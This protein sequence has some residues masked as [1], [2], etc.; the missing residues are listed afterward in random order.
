MSKNMS[1]K[2]FI[3][4]KRVCFVGGCPN[5]KG[6]GYGD[7]IDGYDVVVK[8]NGSLFLGGDDYFIDYGQRIDVLY[9]NN[10]FYREMSPLPL[11]AMKSKGIKHLRM[12][13]CS[14]QDLLE[15]NKYFHAEKISVAIDK[16]N[17]VVHGALMG[18]YIYTDILECEP[19]ELFIVGIDFFISKRKEFK[20]NVYREYLENY[21]PEKIR[22]QGNKINVGKKEDGHSVFDNTKY[23]YD[24]WGKHENMVFPDFIE[25]IMHGIIRRDLEQK[26]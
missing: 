23:I 6:L 19:K 9:T 4:D 2:D 5:M 14:N 8:T 20:K 18:A 26:N 16:V 21:L 1:F 3:K 7:I 11:S 17:Q 15:F 22:K 24:L 12:K 25:E 10:Q 13:T